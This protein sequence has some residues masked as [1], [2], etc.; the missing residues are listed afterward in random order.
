MV[1]MEYGQQMMNV[2]YFKQSTPFDETTLDALAVEVATAWAAQFK[3]LQSNVLT[4]EYVEATALDTEPG[5][6]VTFSVA[7]AG[8]NSSTAPAPSNVTLAVKFASGLTGRSTRGR[9]FWL[10][11]TVGQLGSDLVN[12]SDATAIKAAVVNFFG[13]IFAAV[14]ASHSIVSYCS[15]GAW[16]TTALVTPVQFYLLTDNAIDSQ[17]RRLLGRGR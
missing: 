12:T 6:Q 17:R 16:R 14:A 5:P 15:A 3:P 13:A 1:Y 8:T 7:T 11:L 9:M 10:G 2:F 4:L